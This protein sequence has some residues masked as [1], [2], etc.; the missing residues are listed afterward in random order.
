MVPSCAFYF[1]SHINSKDTIGSGKVQIF[2]RTFIEIF[3]KILFQNRNSKLKNSKIWNFKIKL[4][5]WRL[6]IADALFLFYEIYSYLHVSKFVDRETVQFH[7]SQFLPLRFNLTFALSTILISASCSFLC[8]FVF[9]FSF[10]VYSFSL[11]D[12]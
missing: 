6:M 10:L 7:V 2:A 1:L 4:I 5:Y 9:L 8:L 3:L 12:Y 11:D